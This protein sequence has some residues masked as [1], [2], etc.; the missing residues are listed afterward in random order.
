MKKFLIIF[1][2]VSIAFFSKAQNNANITGDFQLVFQSYNN[3]TIIGAEQPAEKVRMNSYADFLYTN[4]NFSAGIRYEA[5][6]NPLLGYNQKNDGYG[7]PY[8]F[9]KYKL[10]NLE[11]TAGNFYE[12][13]G[14]GLILR[15]YEDKNIGYDNAFDGLRVKYNPSPGLYLTA[16]VGRQRYIFSKI[17]LGFSQVINK[18]LV[19]GADLEF[20]VNQAIKKLNDAST[21]ILLGFSYVSKYQKQE[22]HYVSIND[23]TY[24]LK[25]PENTGAFST[26]LNL[27]A[28]AFGFSGEFA[29]KA[30]DPS[31]ENN[32][33]Y[34]PGNA[35]FLNFTFSKKGFGL[36]ISA[37]RVDNFG[38]RSDRNATLSDLNINYI[39]DITRN[40]IYSFA[41]M[42]PY[43]SQNNGEMGFSSELTFKIKKRSKIGGKYGIDF[44]INY[45]RIHSIFKTKINEQTPINQS[46]TDGYL[47][48]YFKIGDKVFYQDI[49]IKIH[50]KLSKSF[51]FNLIYQN[52]IFNIAE[53]RGE[54]EQAT[55]YAN[56]GIIDFT[57][58][59][60]RRNYLRFETEGLF[61]KQDMGSWA[62]QEI[63]Y[64]I[65][66]HWF[67][68]VND[69]FNYKNPQGKEAHYYMGAM[70]FKND[71]TRIQL[72]YGRQREGVIC[73]G[74]VCRSVPATNGFMFTI[75]TSF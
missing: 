45:S 29:Y 59:L 27:S 20:D 2:F 22:N 56:I 6:F 18:G 32:F 21:H 54:I 10:D 37:I 9:A 25:I 58:K 44:L 55:I 24:A 38:F 74:G 19:R 7:F 68:S 30:Q 12:Q 73:I 34:K 62:M 3:D 72:S 60:N 46:G 41:A 64:T 40:H 1:L 69:Q 66:P 39:P 17:N 53:L 15:T 8:R 51:K 33:I 35:T 5:Y 28:G 52:E 23:S 43:V 67:F 13:F 42:Y 49:N 61:S 14:N 63:E 75:T 31:A 71:N 16:L 65:S 57:V 11:I 50:K 4:N 70:G 47:T 36:L 48:N 26:R